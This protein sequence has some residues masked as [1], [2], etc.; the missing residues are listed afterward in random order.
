MTTINPKVW[1]AG[2][3]DDTWVPNWS[4][5]CTAKFWT[6][7]IYAAQR[8]RLRRVMTRAVAVDPGQGVDAKIIHLKEGDVVTKELGFGSLEDLVK[9]NAPQCAFIEVGAEQEL[10]DQLVELLATDLI[11][12]VI[13]GGSD[14]LQTSVIP[15]LEGAGR[16]DLTTISVD[17]SWGTDEVTFAIRDSWFKAPIKA[18]V[19][20]GY[21]LSYPTVHHYIA[22][23]DM[24]SPP[25]SFP[26]YIY[27]LDAMI[28]P[29]TAP[30][31][32][33]SR[34]LLVPHP[35]RSVTSCLGLAGALSGSSPKWAVSVVIGG[36]TPVGYEEAVGK[37]YETAVSSR[38]RMQWCLGRLQQGEQLS[39]RA[40][41]SYAEMSKE[42]EQKVRKALKDEAV[43]EEEK[44]KPQ[45]ADPRTAP[46]AERKQKGKP[47][48]PT[49]VPDEAEEADDGGADEED[50]EEEG[51]DEI[52]VIHES[53]EM[54]A[55]QAK[56]KAAKAV[57]EQEAKRARMENVALQRSWAKPAAEGSARVSRPPDRFEAESASSSAK[58]RKRP[59]GQA[60]DREMAPHGLRFT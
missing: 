56:R 15:K 47:E 30:D 5:L 37:A 42:Q 28:A 23:L 50:A 54:Q 8:D 4:I 24:K 6:R 2:R 59:P 53:E 33:H 39:Q 14:N 34:L 57:K 12:F 44:R 18:V 38:D 19:L 1:G 40:Y 11:P 17:Q 16:I 35:D 9:W 3:K 13:F 43:K 25:Q 48:P 22:N 21:P 20:G 49:G 29:D 32:T 52:E 58:A 31:A 36:D 27:L 26:E 55:W 45:A 41:N 7:D 46:R 60:P 51:E 10:P